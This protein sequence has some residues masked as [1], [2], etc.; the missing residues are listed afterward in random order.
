MS[1]QIQIARIFQQ[2]PV[3]AKALGDIYI[4]DEGDEVTKNGYLFILANISNPQPNYEQFSWRLS[5]KNHNHLIMPLTWKIL[6][7]KE[8]T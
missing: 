3:H 5:G 8:Y 4:N 6:H 1:D 7:Y 2:N